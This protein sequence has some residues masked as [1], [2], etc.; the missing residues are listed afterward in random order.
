MK[1]LKKMPPRAAALRDLQRIPGVGPKIAHNLWRLGV[2]SVGDLK[3][4][5]PERLYDRLCDLEKAKVDRC[6]L[7]VLR[8]AVYFASRKKHDPRLLKWWNWKEI[9]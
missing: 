4:A 5:D 8:G 7:Y 1:S 3:G 6:A 2:G 9:K